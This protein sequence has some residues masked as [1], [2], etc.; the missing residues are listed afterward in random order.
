M[1]THKTA[2]L[3]SAKRT[4]V[5]TRNSHFADLG[6]D[7]L[8]TPVIKSVLAEANLGAKD[9]DELIVGNALGAG[10]NPARLIALAAGLPECVAGL[11]IDRQCCSGADAL[12]LAKAMI[13]SGQANVVIAGGAESFSLRPQRLARAHSKAQYIAYERPPFTPWPEHDPDMAE[14]ASD[15]AE[16]LNINQLKQ[17]QFAVESHQ[18]ALKARQQRPMIDM[19]MA[20][21]KEAHENQN[22]EQHESKQKQGIQEIVSVAGITEDNFSRQLSLKVCER[23]RVLHRTINTANTAVEADAAAFCLVVSERI[24]QRFQHAIRLVDGM[25]RGSDPTLP[26]LAP[27]A[28]IKQLLTAENIPVHKIKCAEIMEAFAAQT[29][30]CIEQSNIDATITNVGGGALARGH[31]IGASGAI[32]AVR[33]FHELQLKPGLGLAAIA[34]AGGIGTALLLES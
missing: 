1:A 11:S 5:A 12:L 3:I 13:E 22:H 15:L 8:A 31:P 19:E 6:L 24:A 17:N 2:F 34:A 7:R 23:A 10:G 20:R 9:V 32:L 16:Q 28:A 14:A 18:K 27:V 25:T 4:A 29:I 30:A 21:Q 26:G 33:L